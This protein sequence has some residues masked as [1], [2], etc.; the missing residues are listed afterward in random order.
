[1]AAASEN[2]TPPRDKL[3]CLV[4][5][6]AMSVPETAQHTRAL[7]NSTM[8]CIR[9]YAISVPGSPVHEISTG[10]ADSTVR[11]GSTGDRIARA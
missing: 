5:P 7:A 4:A 9:S 1:M 8:Q 11:Y 3:K 10:Q 6:C 2:R